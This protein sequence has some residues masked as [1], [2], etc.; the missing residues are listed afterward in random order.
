MEMEFDL[1]DLKEGAVRRMLRQAIMREKNRSLPMHKRK[2]ESEIKESDDDEATEETEVEGEKLA[3]LHEDQ[4]G[5][6]APVEMDDEDMSDEAMDALT[7]PK[8]KAKA[9][10]KA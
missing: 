9:K 2:P 6:A 3:A 10:K 7:P 8:P 5:K 4:K 1:S